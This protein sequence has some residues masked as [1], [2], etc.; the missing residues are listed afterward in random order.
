MAKA[1]NKKPYF[2]GSRLRGG[3]NRGPNGNGAG[4]FGNFDMPM[5]P[6]V[7][8]V[9]DYSLDKANL[10]GTKNT[11]DPAFEKEIMDRAANLTPPQEIRDK[12]REFGE[13]VIKALELEKTEKT[14]EDVGVESV[15][16]VG[17]FVMDTCTHASDKSDV[18]VQ[19][20]TLPSFETVAALGKKVVENMKKA[21]PKD[22]SVSLPQKYGVN[23]MS[24]KG[25]VR[26]LVTIKP[27]DADKLEP[28]LHLDSRVLMFNCFAVRHS[29]WFQ[30]VKKKMSADF[31][32]EFRALVRVLKAARARFHDFQHLSVWSVQYLAFYCLLNGPNRQKLS[33]GTAFRRFFEIIAAG[34]LLPKAPVIID[35]TSPQHRIGFDMTLAQMDALCMGA[36]TIVRIFAT[37]NDGYRAILG[38]HGSPADLTQTTTTWK[39]VEIRPSVKAFKE[40]CMDPGYGKT[41]AV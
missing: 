13:K 22:T 41:V 23:I 32:L 19:I 1:V 40:G 11:T 4:D 6:P 35:P 16:H 14:L 7:R 31:L 26:I 34:M 37:G 8:G 27:T 3:R 20:N 33:L 18:V 25:K 28:G 2:R 24:P 21:D 10:Q 29:N 9:Y 5:F 39:G 30:D 17:S 36:Q 15:A 12:L 38:T